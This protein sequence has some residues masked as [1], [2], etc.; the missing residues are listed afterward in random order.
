MGLSRVPVVYRG[1]L[2]AEVLMEHTSGRESVSGQGT[3]IREGV[4]VR[5]CVERRDPRLGR[6]Q[7]KSI[8]PKYLTRK[9][10]TEFS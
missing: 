4:V 9:G 3:H 5:P 8:N 1:P 10:G 7:L 2:S 6:V